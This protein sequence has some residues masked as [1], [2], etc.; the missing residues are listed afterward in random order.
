MDEKAAVRALGA[1]A[2]DLRL[3]IHRAVA[4]VGPAGM[5]PGALA[6][7]LA[8]LPSTVSFHVR[9]LLHPGLLTRNTP[10]IGEVP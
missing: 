3:H 7:E 4:G 6:S 8:A 10:N 5:T 2:L 9:Q 1:L